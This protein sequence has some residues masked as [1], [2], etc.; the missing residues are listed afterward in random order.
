MFERIL[1]A[2]DGSE[3]ATAAAGHAVDLAAA[4]GATLHA[5]YV[6][7]TGTNP[8]TVSKGEVRES[9]REVGADAADEALSTVEELADDAGV[10][11]VRATREGSPDGAILAYAT[12]AAVDLVVIGTHGRDGIR[13]RLLGSVTERVV[14]DAPMPVTTVTADGGP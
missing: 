9:L 14:R 11:L 6:V 8:L 3:P 2:T 5:L 12:E 10:E 13:R 7:D 1:V 4:H